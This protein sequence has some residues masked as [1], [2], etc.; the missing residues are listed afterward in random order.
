MRMRK[1]MG[2]IKT[3]HDFVNPGWTASRKKQQTTSIRNTSVSPTVK[4]TKR[5]YWRVSARNMESFRNPNVRNNVAINKNFII[6]F[7][8]L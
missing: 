2:N 1:A 5:L 7:C 3:F 8:F 6:L 4:S